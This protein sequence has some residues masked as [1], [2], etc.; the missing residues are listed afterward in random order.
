MRGQGGHGHV[1]ELGGKSTWLA[2]RAPGLP[3]LPSDYR[4]GFADLFVEALT[5]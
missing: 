3:G 5:F 2:Q 4:L 1:Q